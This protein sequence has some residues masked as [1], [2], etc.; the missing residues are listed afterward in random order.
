MVLDHPTN[1]PSIDRLAGIV[2]TLEGHEGMKIIATYG[3][4]GTLEEAYPLMENILQS[5]SDI[6]VVMGTNDPTSI[7]AIGALEAAKKLDSILVYSID[8]SPEG[9]A[10]VRQE[11][12]MA[13]AAQSPSRI[14]STA[15]GDSL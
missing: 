15:G 11:K 12:M 9:Q 1:K 5:R 4:F 8:G 6:T 3:A 14:G 2:D 13:T 7:G 10:M